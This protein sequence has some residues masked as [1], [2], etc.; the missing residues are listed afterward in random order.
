MEGYDPVAEGE[1]DANGTDLAMLAHNASLSPD[2][3]WA[4]YVASATQV[5]RLIDAAERSG[6]R[7][8]RSNA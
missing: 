2:E 8:S 1:Q 3:R 5:L 6:L 4:S 7:P